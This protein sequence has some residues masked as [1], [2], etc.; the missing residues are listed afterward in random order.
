MTIL[1]VG[2]KPKSALAADAS[3]ALGNKEA[4][5]VNE[6]IQ[7]NDP[8]IYALGDA[9]ETKDFLTDTNRYAALAWPAHRQASIIANDLQMSKIPYHGTLGDRKSVMSGKSVDIGGE[10]DNDRKE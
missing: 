10:Q 1:A 5:T 6:Y 3:L 7:T 4:I 8:D 9:V 2:I